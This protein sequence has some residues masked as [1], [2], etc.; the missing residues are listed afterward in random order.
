VLEHVLRCSDLQGCVNALAFD[1][2]GGLL[3]SGSDD[4]TVKLFNAETRACVQT[5]RGFTSNVFAVRFVLGSSSSVIAGSNDADV[6][7]FDA[8]TGET[9]CLFPHHSRKV[10]S[11]ATIHSQPRFRVR[12]RLQLC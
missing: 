4:T 2:T 6:R 3:A 11:I 10:L 7:L 8:A 9:S 12:S 5:L 1:Q